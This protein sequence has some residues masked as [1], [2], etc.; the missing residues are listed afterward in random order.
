[1]QPEAGNKGI[2]SELGNGWHAGAFVWKRGSPQ[3]SKCAI[4]S[5][6]WSKGRASRS[7]HQGT[8]SLQQPGIAVHAVV[9][10][11]L[12][13][14][15]VRQTPPALREGHRHTAPGPVP[16]SCLNQVFHPQLTAGRPFRSLWSRSWTNRRAYYILRRFYYTIVCRE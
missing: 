14:S 10:V 1:M 9:G 2:S 13:F 16:T 5:G 12:P 6:V 8:V 3:I 4:P 11:R 15:L 7:G